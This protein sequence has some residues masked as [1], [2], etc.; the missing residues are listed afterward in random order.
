LKKGY[1]YEEAAAPFRTSKV[2]IDAETL[3]K[4]PRKL[5]FVVAR[6]TL[7]EMPDDL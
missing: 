5:I 4:Y 3:K 7:V 2:K 6:N 1:S